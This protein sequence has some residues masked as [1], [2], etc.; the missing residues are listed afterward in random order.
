MSEWLRGAA[1]RSRLRA[2]EVRERDAPMRLRAG[3]VRERDAPMRLRAG[4]SP[5]ERPGV[6]VRFLFWGGRGLGRGRR[7]LDVSPTHRSVGRLRATQPA[8]KQGSGA[9]LRP[10]VPRD[11]PRGDAGARSRA[12]AKGLIV[13]RVRELARPHDRVLALAAARAGARAASRCGESRFA[14]TPWRGRR[15]RSERARSS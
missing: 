5:K 2:G 11:R 15:R 13:G 6:G 12:G 9:H 8:P 10:R 14:G 4:G 1:R 7:P 3:E